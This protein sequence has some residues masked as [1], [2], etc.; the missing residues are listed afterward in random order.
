MDPTFPDSR[1]LTLQAL[2]RGLLLES[3]NRHFGTDGFLRY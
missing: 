1:L 2:I 3:W